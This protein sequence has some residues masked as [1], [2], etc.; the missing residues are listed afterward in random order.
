MFFFFSFKKKNYL[1]FLYLE[2]CLNFK[3]IFRDKKTKKNQKNQKK[4]ENF[5]DFLWDINVK[6]FQLFEQKIRNFRA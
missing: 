6:I 5:Q 3:F 2:H 4:T 1:D